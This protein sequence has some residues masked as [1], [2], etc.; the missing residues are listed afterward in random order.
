MINKNSKNK[1][2]KY[3]KQKKKILKTNNIL[4]RIKID[5]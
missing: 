1:L 3:I 5:I 2:N 4:N